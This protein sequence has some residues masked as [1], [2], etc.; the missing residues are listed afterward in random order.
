MEGG[1]DRILRHLGVGNAM[2]L[3][4]QVDGIHNPKRASS[5][6]D[7]LIH[8][9]EL[10]V[11][12]DMFGRLINLGHVHAIPTAVIVTSVVASASFAGMPDRE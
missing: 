5:R 4:V 12:L 9:A 1:I 2:Q 11:V 10:G 7:G 3:F 8:I 6:Y